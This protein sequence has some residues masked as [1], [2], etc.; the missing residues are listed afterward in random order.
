MVELFY[1]TVENT[2]IRKGAGLEIVVRTAN[3]LNVLEVSKQQAT[4][5]LV[6]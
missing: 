5:F 3:I 6:I 4:P 1:F 2:Y